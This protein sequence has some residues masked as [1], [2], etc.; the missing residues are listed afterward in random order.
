M[1]SSKKLN[2]MNKD[3]NAMERDILPKRQAIQS[4]MGDVE[5]MLERDKGRKVDEAESLLNDLDDQIDD[6]ALKREDLFKKLSEYKS[7]I[8][9]AK[10]KEGRDDPELMGKLKE[11]EGEAKALEREIVDLDQKM[12]DLKKK[13]NDSKRLLD[14]I[15]K[16]PGKYTP[17]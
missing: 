9:Q 5:N 16:Q 7:L 6:L 2:N 14:E 3:L 4:L 15:K 17:A 8:T 12:S 10:T 11:L 1:R 13:R